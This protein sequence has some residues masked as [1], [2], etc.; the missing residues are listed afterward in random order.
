[1]GKAV[2]GLAMCLL[3]G[4]VGT[5]AHAEQKPV[6]RQPGESL[7]QA[8]QR[9]HWMEPVGR[10]TQVPFRVPR[11]KQMLWLF[12]PISQPRR[13][14][15]GVRT[16]RFSYGLGSG[17]SQGPAQIQTGI[18]RLPDGGFV[19]ISERTVKGHVESTYEVPFVIRAGTDVAERIGIGQFYE[20]R[21]AARGGLR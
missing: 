1:M 7:R 8:V 13:G 12:V 9:F 4:L 19:G 15:V 14:L 21:T 3:A 10:R 11:N 2:A 6:A 20:L 18:W 17:H 16:E 5:A